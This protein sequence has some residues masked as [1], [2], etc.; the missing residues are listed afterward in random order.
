[1]VALSR[2]RTEPLTRISSEMRQFLLTRALDNDTSRA[3]IDR[4]VGRLL[5]ETQP[6][7][8]N[9][10]SARDFLQTKLFQFPVVL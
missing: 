5:I 8:V 9:L 4:A 3:S 1:M 6:Y 2:G 7:F 10:V